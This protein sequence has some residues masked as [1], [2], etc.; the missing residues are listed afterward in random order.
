MSTN[1]DPFFTNWRGLRERRMLTK[2]EALSVILLMGGQRLTLDDLIDL[3]RLKNSGR[4]TED[5]RMALHEYR[6]LQPS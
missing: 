2:V 6:E 5:E 4:L 1:D 3:D